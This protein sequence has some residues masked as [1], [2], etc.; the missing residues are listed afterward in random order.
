MICTLDDGAN[1]RPLTVPLDACAAVEL[2]V[3]FLWLPAGWMALFSCV[4]GEG[5]SI[6][7]FRS[8]SVGQPEALHVH[9]TGHGKCVFVFGCVALDG[10]WTLAFDVYVRP[11]RVEMC[12]VVLVFFQ[13]TGSL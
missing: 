9:I 7:S 1:W 3:A 5:L 13:V 2:R 6:P 10:V 4:C 8:G 12:F 11:G